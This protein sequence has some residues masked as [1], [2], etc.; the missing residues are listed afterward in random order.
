MVC[1]KWEGTT[2]VDLG[3]NVRF[4]F[5]D[6]VEEIEHQLRT[7]IDN[8][9]QYQQMK[10]IAKKRGMKEFSYQEIAKRSIGE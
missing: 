4:L 8:E 7:L 2:H 6:S 9:D 10:S 5:H 1:K 3:G